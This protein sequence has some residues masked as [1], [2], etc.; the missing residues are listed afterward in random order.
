MF[1][2]KKKK[3]KR[4]KKRISVGKKRFYLY[5][6]LVLLLFIGT[7]YSLLSVNLSITGNVGVN[8][9]VAPT[10]YNVLR[11]AVESGDYARQFSGVHNDSIDT[12]KST[13]KIYYWY[14]SN[15]SEGTAITNKNNVIFANHCWQMIRTTDTGGVKMIYN[16]E[17]ENNQCL[18][19][20]GSHVGYAKETI[21]TLYTSYYYG[22]SYEYDEANNLFTL[23]GTTSTGEIKPGEYTCRKNAVTG[24]CTTLYLV[25]RVRSGSSYYLIPVKLTTNYAQFGILQYN[26]RDE[27]DYSLTSSTYMFNQNY[28]NGVVGGSGTDVLDV[29]NRTDTANYYYSS[30]ITH[31]GSNYTLV[32]PSQ[33]TWSQI[34]SSTVGKYICSDENSSTCYMAFYVVAVDD[35]NEPYGFKLRGGEL[36]TDLDNDV[37]FATSYTDNGNGTY[38]L[39]NPVHLKRSDW[40]TNYSSY[41][42]TYY[43]CGDDLTNYNNCY[44]IS[45][46]IDTDR[47]GFSEASTDNNNIYANS[48]T[49]NSSTNKYT[50]DATNR[51]QF[52]DTVNTNNLALWNNNHYTCLSTSDTC[53]EVYYLTFRENYK[54]TYIKLTN[55]DTINDVLNR[56]LFADDVNLDDSTIKFGVDAWYKNNL[57]TYADF[58]E[59]TIYCTDRTIKNYGGWNPNGGDLT[60]KLLL[61]GVVYNSL[62]CPTLTDSFS[63]SNPKA[64]LTYPVGLL[65]YQEARLVN[66]NNA[67]ATNNSYW[68]GTPY[69]YEDIY[70]YARVV[71]AVGN[72]NNYGTVTYGYGV[73]PAITLKNEVTYFNGDGSMA[74]PY[75]VDDSSDNIKLNKNGATNSPTVY[76]T[77]EQN[78]TTLGT[79]SVLPE[80]TNHITFSLN[81]TGATASSTSEDATFSFLGWYTSNDT[82]VKVASNATTPV[83][84]PNVSGYTDGSGRW[85][86]TDRTTLYAGWSGGSITLPTITKSGTSCYWNTKSNGSGTSYPSG[87]TY[88]PD[89]NTTLYAICFDEDKPNIDI[90]IKNSRYGSSQIPDATTGAGT[91]ISN[92]YRYGT[93]YYKAVYPSGNGTTQFS[94]T[95]T[96]GNGDPTKVFDSSKYIKIPNNDTS[97]SYTFKL[98]LDIGDAYVINVSCTATA[99][100]S[101]SGTTKTTTRDF[102]FG[103]GWVMTTH[104]PAAAPYQS[105][106]H[107]SGNY[108]IADYRYLYNGSY[109]TGWGNIY[110]YNSDYPNGRY[111]WYYYY[112]GTETAEN[113]ECYAGV[114]PNGNPALGISAS[115]WCKNLKAPDGNM[116]TYAGKRVYFKTSTFIESSSSNWWAM[117]A[118]IHSETVQITNYAG[119]HRG[120]TTNT[121]TFDSN[122]I[123]TSGPGC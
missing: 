120:T 92:A 66:N 122:G 119:H 74:N 52:W 106:Y 102:I 29:M 14:A 84:E 70:G 27:T 76:T 39:Q 64:R 111:D 42:N 19:T 107:F 36:E 59:D 10:L 24:T 97:D 37:Y 9:Y 83:L 47:S 58:I 87:G 78:D 21:G 86:K 105:P 101:S 13:E 121:Y 82:S 103:N 12:T 75:I 41:D 40:Y 20:R 54:P 11:S 38:S 28:D 5:S 26:Y 6:I 22:T 18:N 69:G 62:E 60:T 61:D 96:K 79:L 108:W 35:S 91:T 116:S 77:V 65:T 7:G 32:N 34:A 25:D 2:S 123:C 112:D 85:I 98:N 45:R 23:A 33:G 67:R 109:L 8:R 57:L 44:T 100:D 115:G 16:G 81:S 95:A 117:G 17:P 118:L 3:L 56:M 80:R 30:N 63:L 49:Y 72:N 46:I 53:Q 114:L 94:C 15:D 68:L 43:A 90:Y 89:K 48:V 88:T 99:T 110:W 51:V 113:N 31:S 104:D 71:T 4:R 93:I 73:R 50:L 55:G 1:L